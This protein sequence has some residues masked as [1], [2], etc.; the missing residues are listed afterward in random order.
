MCSLLPLPTPAK[1]FWN[2]VGA[3]IPRG[4]Y[5]INYF[6][7]EEMNVGGLN[8]INKC[9]RKVRV[10]GNIFSL[11]IFLS[12]PQLS[13]FAKQRLKF[14]GSLT[15]WG[16]FSAHAAHTIPLHCFPF[17]TSAVSLGK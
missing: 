15:K 7:R 9:S 14:T 3:L 2:S 1:H 11:V 5:I 16:R 17:T 12:L 4:S 10:F 8:R 13:W 6:N